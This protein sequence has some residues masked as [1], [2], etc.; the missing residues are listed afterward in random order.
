M[1]L[2]SEQWLFDLH[3]FD[4]FGLHFESHTFD[5][6]TFTGGGAQVKVAWFMIESNSSSLRQVSCFSVLSW[7]QNSVPLRYHLDLWSSN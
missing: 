7:A 6:L 5:F 1:V 4:W 2:Y 3:W